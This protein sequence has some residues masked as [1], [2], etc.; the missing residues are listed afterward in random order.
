[1]LINSYYLAL[2]TLL[3]LCFAKE[4][5]TKRK[6]IFFQRLRRK[7]KAPLWDR[8]SLISNM[9]LVFCLPLLLFSL[10]SSLAVETFDKLQRFFLRHK[11]APSYAGLQTSYHM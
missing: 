9:A 7:K 1:M 3:F 4:K 2:I 10:S 11:K 5:A 8:S 6:A